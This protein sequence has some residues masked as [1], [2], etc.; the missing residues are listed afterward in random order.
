MG[1]SFAREFQGEQPSINTLSFLQSRLR[2]HSKCR[3]PMSSTTLPPTALSMEEG[4]PITCWAVSRRN[5]AKKRSRIPAVVCLS[6]RRI[7]TSCSNRHLVLK[8]SSFSLKRAE[9]VDLVLEF[10]NLIAKDFVF[11]LEALNRRLENFALFLLCKKLSLQISL[12]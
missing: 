6:G 7:L 12:S 4:T 3:I 11:A 9:G 5:A 10:L 1:L 8:G 2:G